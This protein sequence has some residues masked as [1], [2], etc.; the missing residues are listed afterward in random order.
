MRRPTDSTACPVI[1]LRRAVRDAV[2]ASFVVWPI[3]LGF[4]AAM[5]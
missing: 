1:D 5:P 3:I 2:I 4:M